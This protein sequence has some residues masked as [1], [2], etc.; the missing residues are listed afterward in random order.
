MLLPIRSKNPPESFP[1]AT[2]LLIVI[3]VVVFFLTSDG[4]QIRPEVV[5]QWG[6]TGANFSVTTC[7]TSM[8]LH[9]DL[10]HLLGNMWFLY[11]FGFAV[12]GRLKTP[13]FVFV[14][15]AAGFAGDLL[16]YLV[17]ARLD[18]GLPSIGASGAIMGV[19]G[20]ALF[21]FP[22]GQVEFLWGWGFYH[23]DIVTWNIWHVALYYL[24]IDILLAVIAGGGG[25]VAHFAHIGGAAG[26]ALACAL[27]RP[28]RDSSEASEARAMY[29]ETK[30]LS[31]LSS[32][33]L[34]AMHVS[35]PDDTH[36]VLNWMHRSLRDPY[37]VKPECFAAF[38]RLLPQIVE[39]EDLISLGGVLSGV[40]SIPD[41]V[42]PAILLKTS[43]ALERQG[44]FTLALRLLDGVITN[45]RSTQA[46]L[47]AAMMRS[48]ILCETALGN[49]HRAW[50]TY[51]EIMSRY[52][53]SPM[54]DQAR[55]RLA[56]MA[57]SS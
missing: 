30:D 52:P 57:R 27:L 7:I 25:G 13:K 15:L 31:T 16:H 48:A 20:A 38:Q 5:K 55:L 24:G 44:E 39:R 32:R 56:Q 37:G 51:Q 50:E 19:L 23:M 2:I 11:L 17:I 21:M 26:G 18:P 34:A 1:I 29:A 10:L 42:P 49:K 36:I 12:E 33:E 53:M 43:F 45:Q 28:K 14:Y 6:Q 35:N 40:C 47:E 9:G 54:A 41:I 8:F 4:F 46:D 22:F 3:N